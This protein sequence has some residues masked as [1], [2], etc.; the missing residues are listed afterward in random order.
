MLLLFQASQVF[1][2]TLLKMLSLTSIQIMSS[3]RMFCP[4]QKDSESR[5]KKIRKLLQFTS[6]R[7]NHLNVIMNLR[8]KSLMNSVTKSLTRHAKKLLTF[9]RKLRKQ[10]TKLSKLLINME[11]PAIPAKWKN[12][13][14]ML[15]QSLKRTRLAHQ[16]KL[17][18]LKRLT[19]LP[20]LSLAQV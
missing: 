18:N 15:E 12:P 13:E 3:L 2:T 10:P 7:L 16:L 9:L 5:L 19:S 17:P 1:L 20:T 6:L 14:V 4:K 8:Q 11:N